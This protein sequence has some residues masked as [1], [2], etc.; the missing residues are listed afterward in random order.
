MIQPHNGSLQQ[1]HTGRATRSCDRENGK[2]DMDTHSRFSH[3]TRIQQLG[4]RAGMRKR[5]VKVSFFIP[6]GRHTDAP[7][8]SSSFRARGVLAA[9]RASGL[10]QDKHLYCRPRPA[11]SP[12]SG[13]FSGKVSVQEFQTKHPALADLDLKHNGFCDALV[14]RLRCDALTTFREDVNRGHGRCLLRTVHPRLL[15]IRWRP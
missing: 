4:A 3:A 6:C 14:S 1:C 7:K 15:S 13:A 11:E 2:Q 10:G 9:Y 5:N 12:P 8:G